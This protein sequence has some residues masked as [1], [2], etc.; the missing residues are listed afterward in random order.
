M[1]L[2]FKLLF[3][4]NEY[5]DRAA[6]WNIETTKHKQQKFKLKQQQQQQYEKKLKMATTFNFLF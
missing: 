4:T 1:D 6:K 3:R 2:R 5:L